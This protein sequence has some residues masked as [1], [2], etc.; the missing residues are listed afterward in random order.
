LTVQF[1]E[2][3]IKYL[4][5]H[6]EA[7]AYKDYL[8]EGLFDIPMDKAVYSAWAE[9]VTQRNSIPTKAAFIEFV[10]RDVKRS[11][12]GI[13]PEKYNELLNAIAK[14]YTLA[15]LDIDFTQDLIIEYA[16]RKGMRN[17]FTSQADKIKRATVDDLKA[18]GQE[19][20][21]VL[22]TGADNAADIKARGG[23][24]LRDWDKNTTDDVMAKG[25]PTFLKS[26]NRMMNTKGFHPPQNILLLG[27]PKA[28]KTGVLLKL[29]VEYCRSGL[30]VFV[31]DLENGLASIKLRIKQT[32]LECEMHEVAQLKPEL[33]QVLS[34]VQRY[35]G[36][37]VPH[38]FPAGA[39]TL[40]DVEAELDRL[41]EE[42]GWV[43]NVIIYCM[44]QLFS[45]TNKKL[46]KETEIIQDVYKHAK[47]INNKYNCFSITEGKL[48]KSSLGKW[49][50]KGEDIGK[51]FDQAYNTDVTFVLARTEDEVKAK[52]ARLL[53]LFN[54]EGVQ[55]TGDAFST[56][57]I[58]IDEATHTIEEMDAEAYL[59]L[60]AEMQAAKGA[61]GKKR[62]YVAPDTLKD[63]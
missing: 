59:E 33:K 60:H 51:D 55:Y 9:Y 8:D 45:S 48:N 2:A 34:T 6:K 26:I 29:G 7:R 52:T 25:H 23:F 28:F 35:G 22:R 57:A 4:F 50:P 62:K 31:A 43:P 18:I 21:R 61:N 27:G 44:L 42:E 13:K 12:Q 14:A 63:D 40:G 47:R 58:R 46:F 41:A 20:Y 17:V 1:Q 30:N 53:P 5:Q 16:I 10:D 3:L 56:C 49:A 36:E 15:E 38:Y 32:W 24:M 19:V 11:K 37:I 39:S 54:R